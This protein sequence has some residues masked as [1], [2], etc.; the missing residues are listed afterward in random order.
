MCVLCK[1]IVHM[2]W[3]QRL[4]LSV[5]G[6]QICPTAPRFWMLKCRCGSSCLYSRHCA[7]AITLPWSFF[8]VLRWNGH[9]S[10]LPIFSLNCLLLLRFFF[11]SFY[12]FMFYMFAQTHICAPHGFNSQGDQ[13]GCWILWDWCYR[14]LWSTWVLGIKLEFSGKAASAVTHWAAEVL[15]S[16]L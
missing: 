1:H 8:Q 15:N 7:A 14:Q 12:L 3:S 2:C 10:L 4:E 5:L 11:L 6:L 13:R 16:V 9:L